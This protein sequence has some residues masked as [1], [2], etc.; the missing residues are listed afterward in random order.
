LNGIGNFWRLEKMAGV[1]IRIRLTG[2]QLAA[3]YIRLE[4]LNPHNRSKF[5][6][7]C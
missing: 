7:P 2:G 1:T 6:A 5:R 3:Q 4:Q